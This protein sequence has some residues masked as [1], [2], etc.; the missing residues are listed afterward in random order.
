MMSAAVKWAKDHVEEF[1]V[2]LARQLSSVDP[3]S[4]IWRG[5]VAR[6]RESA[7]MLRDVGLDFKDLVAKGVENPEALEEETEHRALGIKT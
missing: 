5:C 4:E 3:E 7:E 2:I 1:N 6:A